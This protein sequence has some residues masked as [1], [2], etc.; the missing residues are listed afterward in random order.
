MDVTRFLVVI[1]DDFGI[2]PETSRGILELAQRGAVTGTV[3]LVNS[4]HAEADVAAWRRGGGRP[5]LGWHP[6]LTLDAPVLPPGRV[7]SLVGPDGRFWRLGQFLRRLL[8]RRL[9]AEEMAAELR[10][11]LRRFHDLVG[12]A[13]RLVNAH[14]HVQ[15]FPPVGPIL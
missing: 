15:V 6:C 12:S 14:H 3:L 13:P 11:Q 9:R 4:P 10:A 7:P 8:R 1:A 5:Q 2:G